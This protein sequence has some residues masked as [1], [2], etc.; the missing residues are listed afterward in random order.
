MKKEENYKVIL[1]LIYS[2]AMRLEIFLNPS[3]ISRERYFLIVL[4]SLPFA[5]A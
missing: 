2:L 5:T 3:I 1:P 4:P